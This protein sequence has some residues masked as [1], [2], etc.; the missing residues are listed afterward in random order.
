LPAPWG[1]RTFAAMEST[2]LPLDAWVLLAVSVG[3]GLELAF[4]R[5]QRAR[6]LGSGSSPAAAEGRG[7]DESATDASRTESSP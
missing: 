7:S 6:R 1:V 3:L 2:G 4:V 5:A